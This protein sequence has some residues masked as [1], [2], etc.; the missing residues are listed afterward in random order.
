M[1]RLLVFI[2]CLVFF[3]LES[4]TL[5]PLMSK[6]FLDQSKWVDS[7]YNNLVKNIFELNHNWNVDVRESWHK[8]YSK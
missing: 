7:I 4:Q 5:D 2:I 6:D 1:N 8:K 3:K